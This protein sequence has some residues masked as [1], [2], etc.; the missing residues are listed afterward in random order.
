MM[1]GLQPLAEGFELWVDYNVA[2]FVEFIDVYKSLNNPLVHLVNVVPG[3]VG[4]GRFAFVGERA[5][6]QFNH[7]VNK[8]F[9]LFGV[10]RN[11]PRGCAIHGFFLTHHLFLALAGGGD[12]LLVLL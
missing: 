10:A 5:G 9:T 3:Y 12:L 1:S 8:F 4:N 7:F 6:R 2:E 11:L